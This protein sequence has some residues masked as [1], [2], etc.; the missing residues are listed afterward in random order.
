[1]G[2]QTCPELRQPWQRIP[3]QIYKTT[4]VSKQG[5]IAITEDPR[6]DIDSI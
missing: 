3:E 2:M 4:A 6:A 1:M 5:K